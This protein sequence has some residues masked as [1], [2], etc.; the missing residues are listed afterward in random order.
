VHSTTSPCEPFAGDATEH[1]DTG[2]DN[3]APNGSVSR[4]LKP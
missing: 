2:A 3:V 1:P 4:T